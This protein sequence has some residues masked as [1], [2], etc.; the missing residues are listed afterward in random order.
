M[1]CKQK[2]QQILLKYSKTAGKL[3]TKW[4]EINVTNTKRCNLQY[5]NTGPIKDITDPKPYWELQRKSSKWLR[6]FSL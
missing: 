2:M 5:K 6:F 4:R 1:H 3:V